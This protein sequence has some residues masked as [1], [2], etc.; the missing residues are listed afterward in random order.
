MLKPLYKNVVLKKEEQEQKTASG[1]I[2]STETK[3]LPS[4]G[5]VVAVGP[6]CKANL[7]EGDRVVFKQYSGTKVTLDDEEYTVIDEEDILAAIE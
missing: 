7:K 5:K 3:E 1:I 6:E 2:L 4:I